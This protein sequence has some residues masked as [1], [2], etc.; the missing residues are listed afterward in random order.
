MPR[1]T[2]YVGL[3]VMG[4]AIAAYAYL[5][6]PV[7]L[8]Q[9]YEERR[10]EVKALELKLDEQIVEEQRLT[11]RVEHLDSDPVE[12]EAAIRRREHRVRDGETI[13]RVEL[14]PD[15][16]PRKAESATRDDAAGSDE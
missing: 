13:Y 5:R 1:S 4:A 10:G 2:Y 3:L 9:K 12:M 14:P 8:H 11:Q 7:D 16:E 15:I 6:D